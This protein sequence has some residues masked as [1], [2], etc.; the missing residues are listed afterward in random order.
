MAVSRL[1]SIPDCNKPSIGH[2]YCNSHYLRWYR[3]GDPLAGRAFNGEPA[4]WIDEHTGF[5][6][7]DCLI[8]PFSRTS[9]GYGQINLKGSHIGAHRLMCIRV[10]GPAP[11]EKHEAAHSCGKGH[12]G[13]VHPKH[14]RWATSAENSADLYTHGTV[15]RGERNGTAVLTAED[16]IQIRNLHPTLSQRKIAG[17]FGVSRRAVEDILSRKTWG[18]LT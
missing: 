9:H 10:N 2:G 6:G 3:H 1:C 11:T 13:C 17:M 8:W 4:K 18:W 16:V 5:D 14:L 15:N 12:L 7:D